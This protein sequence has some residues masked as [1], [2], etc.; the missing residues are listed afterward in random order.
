MPYVDLIRV[1]VQ[2]ADGLFIATSP[3]LNGLL[4]AHPNQ[5]EVQNDIPN[6]I[7]MLI[8]RRTK[9]DVMVAQVS[10]RDSEPNSWVSI[11]AFLAARGMDAT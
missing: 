8:R 4:I 6:V 11:P 5:D 1:N 10:P 3:D 2:C 9:Q 7:R